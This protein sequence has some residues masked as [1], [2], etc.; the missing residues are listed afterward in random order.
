MFLKRNRADTEKSFRTKEVED[1]FFF[2]T[3]EGIYK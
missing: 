2:K 1:S 3:N